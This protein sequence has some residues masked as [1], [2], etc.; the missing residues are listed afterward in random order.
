M[1]LLLLSFITVIITFVHM[2]LLLKAFSYG[3]NFS[4]CLQNPSKICQKA[5]LHVIHEETRLRKVTLVAR[6]KHN[7]PCPCLASW[8]TRIRWPFDRNTA[9]MFWKLSLLIDLPPQY[10]HHIILS[11][12]PRGIPL[13]LFGFNHGQKDNSHLSSKIS[14][15]RNSSE[16]QEGDRRAWMNKWWWWGNGPC[17]L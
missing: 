15:V 16:V 7:R 3:H 17:H 9:V 6:I 10:K 8:S 4:C 1:V 13:Q 2:P 5:V 14:M 11:V 12:K